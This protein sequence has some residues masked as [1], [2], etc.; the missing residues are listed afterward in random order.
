MH[1]PRVQHGVEPRRQLGGGIEAAEEDRH[2]ERRQLV[3]ADAAVGGA[4]DEELQL[5][6]LE[7]AAVPLLAN[8]IVGAHGR[9]KLSYFSVGVNAPAGLNPTACVSFP[10][11]PGGAAAQ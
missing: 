3:V 7:T 10:R 8:E 1:L 2:Q 6:F 9:R 11:A 5:C 4:A